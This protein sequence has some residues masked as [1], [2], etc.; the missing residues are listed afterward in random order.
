MYCPNRPM[1]RGSL[2]TA[3]RVDEEKA[4]RLKYRVEVLPMARFW[5]IMEMSLPATGGGR[6][7]ENETAR[8]IKAE[9]FRRLRNS[10]LSFANVRKACRR[11]SNSSCHRQ[12]GSQCAMNAYR[13]IVS[14]HKDKIKEFLSRLKK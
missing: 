1:L 6:P 13:G 2:G 9:A 14:K 11:C 10:G 8:V 5:A 7:P 12:A 3:C 4:S